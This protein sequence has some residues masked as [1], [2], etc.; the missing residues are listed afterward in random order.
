MP[1]VLPVATYDATSSVVGRQSI[2]SLT[3]ATVVTNLLVNYVGHDPGLTM[4]ETQAPGANGPTFTD[5][6]WEK[7]R[8]EILK[9]KTKEVKKVITL[10]GSL[11]G[12]KSGTCTAIV[13]DP[14]D[15]A[16]TSVAL[17]T[18]D[19]P[20]TVFVDTGEEVFSGDNPTELTIVVRSHKDGPVTFTADATV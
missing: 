5:R 3:I 7:E 16:G 19:F 17:K 12:S 4:G 2:L 20:C 6:M 9:F 1:L 13:R 8:K 11:S 14:N 18:D 15:V 10:L